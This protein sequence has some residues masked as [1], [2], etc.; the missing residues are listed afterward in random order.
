[1][2]ARCCI[3]EEDI[4]ASALFVAR[5]LGYDKLKS[6]QFK[7]IK[8]FLAGKDDSILPTGYEKSFAMPFSHSS[9][10]LH[11]LG[12]DS[13]S[14]VIVVIPLTTI[15]EDQVSLGNFTDICGLLAKE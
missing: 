6:L 12:G 1:M 10:H 13:L 7:V 14:I 15:V 3:S 4:L 11:Q 8:C 9:D 2:D 5:Q